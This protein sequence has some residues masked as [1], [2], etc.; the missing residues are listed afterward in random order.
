MTSTA[1]VF[2][3]GRKPGYVNMALTPALKAIHID[4]NGRP[5]VSENEITIP[6]C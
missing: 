5:I 3:L 1:D 2:P 6:D 4:V